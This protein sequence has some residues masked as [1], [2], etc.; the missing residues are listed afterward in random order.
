M[1]YNQPRSRSASVSSIPRLDKED[2]KSSHSFI[3]SPSNR[4]KSKRESFVLSRNRAKSSLDVTET[5]DQL[6][7]SKSTPF[8][9][10]KSGKCTWFH[11]IRYNL[12]P[13][14]NSVS[15][16]G[17]LPSL[18]SEGYVPPIESGTLKD[19]LH[20]CLLTPGTSHSIFCILLPHLNWCRFSSCKALLLCPHKIF[21]D[22]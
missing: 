4:R 15:S 12:F 18:G 19:Y 8:V 11:D 17:S 13:A 14:I 9:S 16:G 10:A 20:E 21:F 22:F 3:L 5:E 2:R 6:I 1:Q 7:L